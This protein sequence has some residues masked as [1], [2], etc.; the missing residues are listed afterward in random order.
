MYT[1]ITSWFKGAI[2]LD[3]RVSGFK[4]PDSARA[5]GEGMGLNSVRSLVH[6][7]IPYTT[8]CKLTLLLKDGERIELKDEDVTIVGLKVEAERRPNSENTTYCILPVSLRNLGSLDLD[9]SMLPRLS[10]TV[11]PT[12]EALCF[13]S[14][15]R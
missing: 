2:V 8:A 15:G 11:L 13:R 14:E 10:C 4:D 5:F 7:R 6:T 12:F 9:A 3:V 1:S